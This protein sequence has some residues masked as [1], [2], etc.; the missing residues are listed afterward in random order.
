MLAIMIRHIRRAVM[1]ITDNG[2]MTLWCHCTLHVW[3]AAL[4]ECLWWELN[5]SLGLPWTSGLPE[6]KVL[7]QICAIWSLRQLDVINTVLYAGRSAN[8]L[9]PICESAE[10]EWICLTEENITFHK[11]C[12]KDKGLFLR[13]LNCQDFSR[14]WIL[15]CT[16]LNPC[17]EKKDTILIR[18]VS[19]G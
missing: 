7:T 1:A 16:S 14:L 18:C 17:R 6:R 19:K 9:Q 8:E 5:Q 10:T 13:G 11:L 15:A 2:N 4:M 12:I 3:Q